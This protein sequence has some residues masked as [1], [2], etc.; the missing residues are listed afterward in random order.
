MSDSV[1]KAP[2]LDV[3]HERHSSKWRRFPIDVLPM[4]VAEMDFQIAE[5]IR[6]RLIKMVS[7]SDLGYTGPI[8]EVAKSFSGFAKERWNWNIDE[9]QLK[10]VTDV[11]VGVVEFLRANGL[12]NGKVIVNS[13]VYHGFWEWLGE[14]N[15]EIV[16]VPLAPNYDLDIEGIEKQFAGGVKYLLLCNPQNPVG[17]AFSRIQLT[18]L[19]RVAK[20]HGAVVISDEIHAP[21]TYEDHEFTPY[22]SCG[23][24]SEVTG[25]CVTSSSKSW[26][27]AGLKAG[28]V[29][30]QSEE[31]KA[32]ADRMPQATHWRSSLLGAFAL[33]EAY[34]NG[35]GWLDNTVKA[36]DDNRKF[37]KS[38]LKNRFPEV[39]FDLPE[40]GYLAWLNVGA[41]NLGADTV[42]HLVAK[43]RVSL[44]PGNDH[45][46]EYTDFVRLNF[47][48]SQEHISEGLARIAKALG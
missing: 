42:N 47:G 43:G 4:H 1:I 46:P 3:L 16:D 44:V 19:A 6:D 7:D 14:L 34:S 21:L 12:A 8:P 38:E 2:S 41:W 15:I 27:H 35:T 39:R 31:M 32:K 18:E 25:I 23:P 20:K 24:D 30:T 22:L 10:L 5:G 9:S 13:P 45:G 40:A 33:V 48:T 29:L 36:L 37:L 26:N 28:F 17:K 11:G